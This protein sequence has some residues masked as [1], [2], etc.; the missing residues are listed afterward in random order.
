VIDH[1]SKLCLALVKAGTAPNHGSHPR[2]CSALEFV[3]QS[4]IAVVDQYDTCT[5][6]HQCQTLT[7]SSQILRYH[8][9]LHPAQ[10]RCLLVEPVGEDTSLCPFRQIMPRRRDCECT[11]HAARPIV[12]SSRWGKGIGKP[13]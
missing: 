1:D 5:L 13:T 8:C 11:Y 3:N 4:C 10:A 9:M 6:S 12:W 7:P 2:Y